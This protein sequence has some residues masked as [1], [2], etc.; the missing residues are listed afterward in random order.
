M[1]H[2]MD[3]VNI[4]IPRR[5]IYQELRSLMN[6]HYQVSMTGSSPVCRFD[7]STVEWTS[8]PEIVTLLSWSSKLVHLGRKVQWIFRDPQNPIEGIEDMRFRARMTLRNQV[9]DSFARQLD[10]LRQKAM[11]GRLYPRARRF[12][13]RRIRDDI[14]A[15]QRENISIV[16]Q[17]LNSEEAPLAYMD[18]LA[19]LDRYR[20][21]DR[22]A[23]V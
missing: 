16:D 3:Y 7:W 17:W 9:Y 6:Q 18:V 4:L 13:F 21:F 8:L 5:L 14:S 22:A 19:Y 10:E 12:E 23:E 20:V 2:H 11:R 1:D 15:R